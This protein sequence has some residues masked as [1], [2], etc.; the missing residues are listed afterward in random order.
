MALNT[1]L[2]TAGGFTNAIATYYDRRLLDRLEADLYF[3]QFGD[4]KP[5]PKNSGKVIQWR[6]YANFAANVTPMVEGT[7]PDGLTL[8]SSIVTAT[9]LQYGDYVAMSD[10]LRLHAIDPVIEGAQD[11]LSYRASLSIDTLIRNVLDGNLTDQFAAGVAAEVNVAANLVASE[12]RKGR[13]AL[14]AASAREIGSEFQMAIHP[15]Q[16]FDL[17][18]DTAV[19]GWLD[20]N[21][22]VS[23]TPMLKGEVGKIYGTRIVV[24]PNIKV[25][26]AAGAAGVDTYHA[27]MFA[28]SCYGIVDLAGGN[29]KTYVK[30]LGSSGVADPLDQISTVGHKFMH[31]TKVLDAV[32]G[33]QIYTA[34]GY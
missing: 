7:V 19:G 27:F 32:R 16:E 9:P 11:V 33:I 17:Q 12:I 28:K 26:A 23:S 29:L 14:K 30:Q 2:T 18:G 34:S 8:A 25:N 6:R 1:N 22:Y 13:T 15:H 20:I 24:S 21:K 4:K 5:M 3:D 31:V 10:L